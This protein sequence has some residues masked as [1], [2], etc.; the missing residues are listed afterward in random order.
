MRSHDG[1]LVA[2]RLGRAAQLRGGAAAPQQQLG[3]R[4]PMRVAS[5][6]SKTARSPRAEVGGEYEENYSDVNAKLLDYFTFKA[7]RMTLQQVSRMPG[8]ALL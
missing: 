8:G 4:R 1:G 6:K 2:L 3:C 7:I 5:S